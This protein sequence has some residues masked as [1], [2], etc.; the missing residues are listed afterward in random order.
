MTEI[1][2]LPPATFGVVEVR[3]PLLDGNQVTIMAPSKLTEE[4]W[5]QLMTL[6]DTLKPSITIEYRPVFRVVVQDVGAR[7]I[8]MIKET[9]HF[10]QL[11]LREAKDFVEKDLP[12]NFMTGLT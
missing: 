2:R 1:N 9:R 11:G 5:A 12:G 8:S 6:L 3:L 4:A 7:K 10:H